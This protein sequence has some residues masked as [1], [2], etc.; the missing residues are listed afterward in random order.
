V[1]CLRLQ[2]G[3]RTLVARCDP[4]LHLE[5]ESVLYMLGQ[6]ESLGNPFLD[7]AR[8]PFGWSQI[9]FRER[10]ANELTLCEPR[11]DGDPFAED[12]DDITQTL[13]VLVEQTAIAQRLGV[14]SQPTPFHHL[15]T[16][17][18][19]ALEQPRIYVERK[20]QTGADDS[21]W[22]IGPWDVL[23]EA[24]LDCETLHVYELLYRRPAVLSVLALPRGTII[25]FDG[26]SI[27]TVL[28]NRDVN[29]WQPS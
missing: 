6:I 13:S 27:E 23:P 26:D 24:E 7:G 25:A 21:G 17:A 15:I 9:T 11:F 4:A 12:T 5:A 8:I 1:N 18:C 28:D 22:Y 29:L 3:T 10:T 14:A 19:G 20:A 2:L 16:V